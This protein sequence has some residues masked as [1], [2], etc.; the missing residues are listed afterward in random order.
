MVVEKAASVKDTAATT[1]TFYPETDGMPLADGEYQLDRFLEMLSILKL[2]FDSPDIVV[3]GNTIIYYVEG[4]NRIWI[5]PDCYIAFGVS[6]DLMLRN[7]TYR[8]WEMGKAPDFVLEIGSSSTWRQD[9]GPKRDLYARLGVGEYWKFDPSG[10]EHYGEPLV[11]ET[12]VGGEYRRM[13]IVR[14]SD[15]RVWVHSPTLNLELHWVDGRLRFYDPEGCRW[16]QNMGEADAARESAEARV[17]ELE[18]ELR[19]LRGE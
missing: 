16:L 11:G 14:E 13:E 8:L 2:F 7:N 19:R 17:A 5:S 4:N 12:L 9:M 3:S 10:G 15:G 1:E 18:A 6:R